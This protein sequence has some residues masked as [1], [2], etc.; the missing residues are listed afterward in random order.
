MYSLKNTVGLLLTYFTEALKNNSRYQEYLLGV[1]FHD[2]IIL[3]DGY[4][5]Y[6]D[7]PWSVW[8]RGFQGVFLV[9]GIENFFLF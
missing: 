7:M 1:I 9:G 8:W 3:L 6:F 2:Y 4:V 5:A